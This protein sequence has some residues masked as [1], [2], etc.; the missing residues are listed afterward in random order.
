MSPKI[1]VG[2]RRH[3]T[4]IGDRPHDER[5]AATRVSGDEKADLNRDRTESTK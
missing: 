5:C 3:G 4:T 1:L 2:T